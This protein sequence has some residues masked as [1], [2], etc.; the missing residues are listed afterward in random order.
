TFGVEPL[1]LSVERLPVGADAGVSEVA[2]LRASFE[3]APTRRNRVGRR[4]TAD[5]RAPLGAPGV[6]CLIARKLTG[7]LP[8][9]DYDPRW[10]LCPSR[11][12]ELSN[13]HQGRRALLRSLRGGKA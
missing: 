10:C 2:I 4:P 6:V 3:R 13:R 5:H 11:S 12:A 7:A 8:I 1:E 9:Q